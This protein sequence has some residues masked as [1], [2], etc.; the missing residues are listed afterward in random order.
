MNP[1]FAA[2]RTLSDVAVAGRKGDMNHVR[3]RVHITP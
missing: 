3:E 2:A 1:V